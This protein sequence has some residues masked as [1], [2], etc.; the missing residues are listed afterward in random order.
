M[1]SAVALLHIEGTTPAWAMPSPWSG[2]R[3]RSVGVLGEGAPMMRKFSAPVLGSTHTLSAVDEDRL[4]G[5]SGSTS[6][7]GSR[8][9]LGAPAAGGLRIGKLRRW[10]SEGA[11]SHTSRLASGSYPELVAEI[12]PH[13]PQPQPRAS[14]HGTHLPTLSNCPVIVT[15]APS[16]ETE[17]KEYVRVPSPSV[18]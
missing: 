16:P 13:R 9:G 18:L 11:E 1:H 4:G 17:R 12:P 8:D 3:A 15:P 5:R 14:V 6:T 10:T 7:A 2:A